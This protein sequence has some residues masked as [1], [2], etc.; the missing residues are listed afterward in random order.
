MYGVHSK[1][2]INKMK[3]VIV[4]R[5]CILR[6]LNLAATDSNTFLASLQ[7]PKEGP[8]EVFGDGSDHS[9]ALTD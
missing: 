8:G 9:W 4:W 7:P 3:T 6:L 2:N 1:T 5:I